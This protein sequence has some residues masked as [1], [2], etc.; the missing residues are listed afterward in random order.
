[1]RVGSE[2]A[3]RLHSCCCCCCWRNKWIGGNFVIVLL[4]SSSIPSRSSGNELGRF[5]S[6]WENSP[7]RVPPCHLIRHT[8]STAQ[9]PPP[10]PPPPFSFPAELDLVV[11]TQIDL[12]VRVCRGSQQAGS[13]MERER[14]T[15]VWSGGWLEV[16]RLPA[17]SQPVQLVSLSARRAKRRAD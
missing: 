7:H 6:S 15:K 12:F 3:S 8:K 10:L 9:P 2:R 13:A 16:V 14:I 5:E 17:V 1:M 4:F 11:R